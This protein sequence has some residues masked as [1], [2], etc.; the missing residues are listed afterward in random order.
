M[1]AGN[2][3]PNPAE[4]LSGGGFGELLELALTKFDRVV[5]DSAPVNA[6][7]DS[8]LLVRH[9]Q[10]VCL[11]IHAA[12][13]PSKAAVRACQKLTEAGGRPVGFILN[14]LPAHGGAGYY[15][16]YSAGEYGK[17]VY[18]APAGKA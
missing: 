10:S 7:A 1:T 9:V 16:H 18:G 17:G 14:R 12:K 4:L 2:R 11:V 5:I 3:A 8:L 6:V 13:T 15:Y